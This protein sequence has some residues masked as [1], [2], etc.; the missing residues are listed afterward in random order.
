MSTDAIPNEAL[1]VRRLNLVEN[2]ERVVALHLQEV[3]SNDGIPGPDLSGLGDN[4]RG[5]LRPDDAALEEAAAGGKHTDRYQSKEEEKTNF[6]LLRGKLS[7]AIISQFV[8][9][10]LL[11]AVEFVC[12]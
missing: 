12:D 5:I 8:E 3:T 7:P 11:P 10:S 1:H 4:G 6:H 9:Y 2:V